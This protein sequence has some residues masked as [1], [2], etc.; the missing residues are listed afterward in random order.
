[1][2]TA[3]YTDLRSVSDE[4]LAVV[5]MDTGTVL[6]TNLKVVPADLLTEEAQSSDS[7]AFVLAAEHGDDLWVKNDFLT[8]AEQS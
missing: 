4:K 6:G 3:S 5:D 2:N 1:M 7:T 8:A